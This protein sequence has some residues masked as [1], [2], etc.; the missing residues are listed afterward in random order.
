M[1]AAQISVKTIHAATLVGMPKRTKQV[2]F[3]EIDGQKVGRDFHSAKDAQ[4]FLAEVDDAQIK[5][6]YFFDAFLRALKP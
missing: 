2:F 1:T 4:T 3:V 6:P 5:G